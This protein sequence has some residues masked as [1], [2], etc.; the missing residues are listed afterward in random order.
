MMQ[1]NRVLHYISPSP[2]PPANLALEEYLVATLPFNTNAI[3]FYR[4]NSSVIIGK[5]QNPWKECNVITARKKNIGIYRRI[6]GGGTVY[7]DEGNLNYS[8]IMNKESY[9]QNS[10]YDI[11]I[12]ALSELGIPAERKNKSDIFMDNNKISGNSFYFSKERVLHHGTLLVSADL[13]MIRGLL[14]PDNTHYETKAVCSLPSPVKNISDTHPDITMDIIQQH[15]IAASIHTLSG[16]RENFIC[17][18]SSDPQY[19]DLVEKH[20][21]REWI[22]QRTPPFS[23]TV[24]M[25]MKKEMQRITFSVEQGMIGAVSG[26]DRETASML[27]ASLAG[28]EYDPERILQK[29]NTS[30]LASAVKQ[31]LFTS[32]Q[33]KLF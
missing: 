31:Q 6:S 13:S 17:P 7:H 25:A 18:D 3:I 15:I 26:S 23:I 9:C 16:T 29:I 19:S 21:S 14:T 5:H 30:S 2:A 20:A 4:N 32:F 22:F 27:D 10:I 11:I 28:L 12:N 1:A 33:E 24:D 8:F